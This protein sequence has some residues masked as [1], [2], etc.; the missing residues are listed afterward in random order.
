[1]AFVVPEFTKK[2]DVNKAGDILAG[3]VGATVEEQDWGLQ[4]LANWRALTLTRINTFPGDITPQ[5][6][7]NRC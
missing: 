5:A 1:M 7:I 3:R 2:G 6:K 4:V